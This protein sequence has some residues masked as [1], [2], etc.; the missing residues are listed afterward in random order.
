MV[1]PP[2]LPLPWKLVAP[3]AAPAASA[4]R[5]VKPPPEAVELALN[6]VKPPAAPL[7]DPPSLRN[8]PLPALDDSLKVVK[9]PPRLP[10]V[11]TST[12]PP[13]FKKLTE[14]AVEVLSNHVEPQRAP[15]T[16]PEKVV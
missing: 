16:P 3:P 15:V 6:S 7:A 9:P 12:Y 5:F 1:A 2:A 4:A 8:A 14:Y 11:K 10:P 13:R